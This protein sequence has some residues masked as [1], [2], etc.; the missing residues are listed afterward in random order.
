MDVAM[1]DS[2][3]AYAIA[4]NLGFPIYIEQSAKLMG[5]LFA[6]RGDHERAFDFLSEANDMSAKNAREAVSARISELTERY[7]SESKKRQ[8]AALNLANE[9]QAAVER[10]SCRAHSH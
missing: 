3:R 10:G 1:A 4:Q 7:Q 5:S 6:A 8:L 9:R 2:E